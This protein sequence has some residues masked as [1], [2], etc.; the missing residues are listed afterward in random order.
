MNI[1]TDIVKWSTGTGI[2]VKE[3]ITEKKDKSPQ[4]TIYLIRNLFTKTITETLNTVR[5]KKKGIQE[6]PK[7]ESYYSPFSN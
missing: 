3:A 2:I 7:L 1:M 4:T 6:Q 5:A